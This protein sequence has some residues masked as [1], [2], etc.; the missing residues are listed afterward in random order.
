MTKTEIAKAFSKGEIE[1]PYKFI[2]DN[3]EWTIIEED[4]F[5]GRQAIPDNC[6]RL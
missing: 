4:K 5:I 3:A 6:E 1:Q 2:S